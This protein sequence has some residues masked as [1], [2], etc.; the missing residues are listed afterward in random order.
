M[1]GNQVPPGAHRRRGAA[2]RHRCPEPCTGKSWTS[3]ANAYTCATRH[4]EPPDRD[5]YR[6]EALIPAIHVLWRISH[7]G[8]GG[9][10]VC[11][12]CGCRTAARRIP[13]ILISD[14][15][16]LS[17]GKRFLLHCVITVPMRPPIVRLPCLGR[18]EGARNDDESFEVMQ[19]MTSSILIKT[20]AAISAAFPICVIGGF[21]YSVAAKIPFP[22][23]MKVAYMVAS[24][25][26][27]PHPSAR[28]LFCD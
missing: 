15:I 5:N 28:R 18:A 24:D 11:K 9:C 19:I 17:K 23:A 27:G 4:H 22:K 2:G 25:S 21:A 7:V 10:A 20:A 12:D 16:Q 6:Q 8:V 3:R 13:R 1:R 26:P 14:L